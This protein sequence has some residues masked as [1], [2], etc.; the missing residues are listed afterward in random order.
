[1]I[2]ASNVKRNFEYY[3]FHRTKQNINNNKA[4]ANKRPLPRAQPYDDEYLQRPLRLPNLPTVD[5]RQRGKLPTINEK[6]RVDIVRE[7]TKYQQ[8][9]QW[10]FSVPPEVKDYMGD[11]KRRYK[12]MK[13]EG[14]TGVY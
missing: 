9:P 5:N 3:D 4:K 14:Y 2:P 1:M 8:M 10:D 13:P 12:K 6:R 11:P 7:Y